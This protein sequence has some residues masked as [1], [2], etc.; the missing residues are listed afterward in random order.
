MDNYLD[1]DFGFESKIIEFVNKCSKEIEKDFENLKI[2]EE[3][4]Q[5]KV[6]NAFKKQKLSATDF[7]W[8]TGYGYGDFG[9]EKLERIYCDIFKANDA[10][11]RQEITCGTHAISLALQGTLY[12]GDEFIYITGTPYDTLL[13]VIGLSGNEKGTLSDYGIKYDKVDLINNKINIEKVLEKINSKT[14]LLAIQRSPGYSSRQCISISELETAIKRIKEKYPNLIIMVDNCYCEF[15][16]TKEPIEVG[17][18]IVVG[19]LL[20]NLGAGITLN[21]GYIVSNSTD[22]IES[23]SNRLTSPGLGKHVGVSFGTT[24]AIVQGLYFAP[25]VVNEAVKSAKLFSY[26]FEKLGYETI[27]KYNDNRSDIIQVIT[28]KDENKVI[29]FCR[30]I[31]EYCCVDSHVTPYPWDMPGYSDKII[32]ASG[33]FIDGSSIELS[34]D[35]PLREPF[36]V[37]YQGGLNYYQAKI[38]LINVLNTFNRKKYISI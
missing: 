11:V 14:K 34:A 32:M 3:Y 2:V 10:I 31:Q 18:N 16:E 6:L 21:G 35:G 12:P 26:A 22:L 20:K 23:I 8:T 33:S 37:Y 9:R 15:V 19:S 24:R 38:A 17:A 27:P 1:T 5:L 30:S 36:N 4:N 29:D 25:H 7:S 28:L 13:K